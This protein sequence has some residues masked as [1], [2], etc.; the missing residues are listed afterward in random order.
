MELTP[1][2]VIFD[3]IRSS[4]LDIK[5]FKGIACYN[6]LRYSGKMTI[7]VCPFGSAI[8]SFCI[9]FDYI[10]KKKPLIV[11][12]LLNQLPWTCAPCAKSSIQKNINFWSFWSSE[13][14]R[15][16]KFGVWYPLPGWYPQT[17]QLVFDCTLKKYNSPSAPNVH[18]K[19][20]VQNRNSSL[21]FCQK[22]RPILL[23]TTNQM[24]VFTIVT[25]IADHLTFDIQTHRLSAMTLWT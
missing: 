20:Q 9:F 22:M 5:F 23:D 24:S 17:V 16:D 1:I 21:Q 11:F 6:L 19:Q 10:I 3:S 4:H 25:G 15:D 7:E 14:Y 13:S 12:L 18:C 2:Q 8:Y